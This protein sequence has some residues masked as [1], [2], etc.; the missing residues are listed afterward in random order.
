MIVGRQ[1]VNHR[2]QLKE[3]KALGVLRFSSLSD[4]IA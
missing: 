2:V 3:E 4:P 1:E